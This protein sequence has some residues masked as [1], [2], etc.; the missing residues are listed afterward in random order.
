MREVFSVVLLSIILTFGCS[1]TPQEMYSGKWHLKFSG[2]VTSE[3]DFLIKN[4][5]T[6][7]FAQNINVNGENHEVYFSGEIIE[8]GTL[9][10]SIFS[11]GDLVG[12][13][14]GSIAPE[15]GS[16]AWE[17]S[18]MEGTWTAAKKTQ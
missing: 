2:D 14:S 3:F 17:G 1:Q 9:N 4:D 5:L 11:G 18:G 16:G 7:S 15:A 10:G 12:N 13:I 6:F 8:D